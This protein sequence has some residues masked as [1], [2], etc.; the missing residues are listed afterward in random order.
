M[1]IFCFRCDLDHQTV[2]VAAD[3]EHRAI[4]HRVSVAKILARLGEVLS[5][6]D[7]TDSVPIFQRLPRWRMTLPKC[8]QRLTTQN[9]HRQCITVN[10][11]RNQHAVVFRRNPQEVRRLHTG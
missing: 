7:L 9:K 8:A 5:A 3:I 4:T 2:L 11:F 10:K 6:C 1:K